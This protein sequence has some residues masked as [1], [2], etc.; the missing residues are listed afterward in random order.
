MQL[1]Y[2]PVVDAN[3]EAIVSFEALIRWNSAEHGFVSPVKFIPLAEDTRLIVPIGT[4]VLHEA[5]REAAAE[6]PKDVKVNVNVSPEQLLEPDFA[7]TVVRALSHSG[8]EPHRL[9]IEVTESIFMRDGGVAR[10]ALEQ[11][12]ALGC[13]IALD[14]FGT[15]YSS[16]G[17]LRK[18][19]FSTIKVDRSFV[20]G[21]NQGSKSEA[22]IRAV[23]GMGSTLGMVAA[24]A[25]AI[26]V[27][28]VLG[29]RL[30]EKTVRIGAS[31]L[32]VVFGLLLLWEAVR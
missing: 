31:L 29:S 23:S 1:H 13:S 17:Y 20:S 10:K 14:D 2:Q 27:G 3:S 4:W 30:P 9:E 24:D 11:C 32:F 21:I 26:G 22:I 6:W 15:G 25:L 12:M 16:L 7:A 19:K 18:L 8:L 5:C 28:Q